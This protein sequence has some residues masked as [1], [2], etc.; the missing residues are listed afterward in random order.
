M[1][2]LEAGGLVTKI[3]RGKYRISAETIDMFAGGLKLVEVS[4]EE[5]V[6]FADADHKRREQIEEDLGITEGEYLKAVSE[7]YDRLRA[8]EE[9]TSSGDLLSKAFKIV[10]SRYR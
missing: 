3:S 8:N 9:K 2:T 7:E 1:N 4:E 5:K 10:E 6:K